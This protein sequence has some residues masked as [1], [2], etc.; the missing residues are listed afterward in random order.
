MVILHLRVFRIKMNYKTNFT[1]L[2]S[3]CK[4]SR[5]ASRF[6]EGG[7]LSLAYDVKTGIGLQHIRHFY[8]AIGGLV[9]FKQGN[10][11]SRRRKA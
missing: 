6:P 4:V 9:V 5:Y 8:L 7:S 10:H 3:F 11:E 1:E 2:F